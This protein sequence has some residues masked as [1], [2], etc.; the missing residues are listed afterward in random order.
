MTLSF[1]VAAALFSAAQVETI[2]NSDVSADEQTLLSSAPL[3]C[4]RAANE[5]QTILSSP[6]FSRSKLAI[7]VE[8]LEPGGGVLFSHNAD[9]AL[10]PAS[11]IK[12]VT[13][14][15]ALH[16]FSPDFRFKTELLGEKQGDTI[17]GDLYVRGNGDPWLVPERLWYLV[18]RLYY[19]G[20]KRVVGNIVIDD[21]YFSG[22]RLPTGSAQ[23]NSSYAYNAPIGAVSA[24][25]NAI[26]VHLRPGPEPGT[27]AQVLIEP[28]SNYPIIKSEVI[29]VADRR[30]RLHVDVSPSQGRS[31]VRISGRINQEDS[32]RAYWRRVDHP[33]RFAGEV[34]KTLLQEGGIKILG[35]IK[36]GRVPQD[37]PI[38][39]SLSSLRLTDLVNRVNK[40]SNNFMAQQLALAMGARVFGC[41]GNLVQ[42]P[43]GDRAFHGQRSR[44]QS[45]HLFG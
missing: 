10:I 9:R 7:H 6:V 39:A 43:Q 42:S 11:N 21:S 5:L 14:A 38:L 1:I 41:P 23:D 19:K 45:G 40:H 8:S 13:T 24:A 29:T 33:P 22:S 34:M 37:T 26:L 28:R 30:T 35:R 31:V 15:A 27:P 4:V 2:D 44:H 36:R 20:V 25:F 17:I 32:G 18:N 3:P 12:L 16:Y